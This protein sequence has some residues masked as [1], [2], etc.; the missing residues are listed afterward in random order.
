MIDLNGLFKSRREILKLSRNTV[1]SERVF[2]AAKDESY[3]EDSQ[4][5]MGGQTSETLYR[6]RCGCKLGES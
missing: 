4:E 2:E 1:T 5:K 3:L 6:C